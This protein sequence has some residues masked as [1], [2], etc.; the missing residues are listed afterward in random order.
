[1][2]QQTEHV[3]HAVSGNNSLY[4]FSIICFENMYLEFYEF[5]FSLAVGNSYIDMK[6]YI[7]VSFFTLA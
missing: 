4:V 5:S 1:M 7:K 2:K 6:A 3:C